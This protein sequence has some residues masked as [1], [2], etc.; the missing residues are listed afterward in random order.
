MTEKGGCLRH[1]LLRV[2]RDGF[3]GDSGSAV[4]VL[5]EELVAALV[6]GSLP[7]R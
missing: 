5:L 2:V 1:G 6:A 3:F 4:T 7:A